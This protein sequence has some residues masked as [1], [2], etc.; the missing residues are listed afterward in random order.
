M[1]TQ[2]TGGRYDQYRAA[3][4]TKED[5]AWFL[6]RS[7]SYVQARLTGGAEFTE[8]EIEELERATT[9]Y[10]LSAI[11]PVRFRKLIKRTNE[12]SLHSE[13]YVYL[14]VWAMTSHGTNFRFAVEEARKVARGLW[15]EVPPVGTI[16]DTIYKETEAE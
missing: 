2:K 4:E 11:Y 14:L 12:H 5:L 10:L 9:F 16:I 8:K 1:K 7:T 15:Y 3:F 13:A 6:G